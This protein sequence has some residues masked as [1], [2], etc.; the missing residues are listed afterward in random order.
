MRKMASKGNTVYIAAAVVIIIVIGSVAVWWY[1][2]QQ[3]EHKL[4]V[5][6]PHSAAFADHVI[7][8]FVAWVQETKGYTVIVSQLTPG[9]S[10]VVLEQVFAWEGEPEADI[11]WGGGS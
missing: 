6:H 9:G 5:I 7:E 8:D 10:G 2:S 4:V 11:F 3:V 1:Y